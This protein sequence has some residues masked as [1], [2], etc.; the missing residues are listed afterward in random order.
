M[1]YIFFGE[2]T[3]NKALGCCG[4]II[5]G[6]L[7]GI[8]QE[9]GLGSL[10]LEGVFFGI[11][12][13]L[14]VA[15]NAIYTKKSLNFVENNIWKLTMY[16]NV[17]ACVIFIPFIFIFGEQNQ[18]F[19]FPLI[20]DSFFW[21]TMVIGGVLGFSMGYVTSLQIQAT[22]PLTHNV[23]GT[24]KAYAQTLLGVFYF[25]E[26]K[27]LLWWASNLFVLVGAA[28]YSH[29]RNQEM[30]ANHRDSLEVPLKDSGINKLEN[31]DQQNN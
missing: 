20:F 8:D 28:L 16:N 3:S 7:L 31:E 24:A 12:A 14:F 1:T 23:S 18:V 19:D 27:T 10:S 15:L 26:I 25:N 13:S 21:F 5:A 2:K 30:K 4:I 9:N 17:N 11:S 29:V 22:S 6:F